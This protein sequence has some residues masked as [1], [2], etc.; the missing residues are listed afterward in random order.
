MKLENFRTA[1]DAVKFSAP[2]YNASVADAGVG[3]LEEEVAGAG[4][5]EASRAGSYLERILPSMDCFG[6]LLA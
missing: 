1:F 5:V 2:K 3:A 4:K 6:L